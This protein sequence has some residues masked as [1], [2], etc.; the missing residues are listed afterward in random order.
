MGTPGAS[1]GSLFVPSASAPPRKRAAG[2]TGVARSKQRVLDEEE[3]IEGRTETFDI[4]SDSKDVTFTLISQCH[5][6]KLLENGSLQWTP[7]AS[8]EACTLEILARD[9][10]TH[11]SS[12]LQPQTTICFC[13]M[14]SQCLYNET[15]REGNSSLEVASCKC[16]GDTFGRFC[17][18][19]KDLCEEPCFPDVSCTPGKGCEACPPNMT[20]DGRHCAAL[21]DPLVCQNHSCP[22]NHCY[23]HG[24]CYIS[25]APD[26]Q[27]ACT[28][29]PAFTDA[30]CFLAGNNFTPTIFKELPL[31]TIVLS[32]REDENASLGDVNASVSVACWTPSGNQI[33]KGSH[34]GNA[35]TCTSFNYL[36]FPKEGSL[37]P[38]GGSR[39]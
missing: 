3:Y 1:A 33:L 14:E 4:T 39:V 19:S 8:P 24:H 30:R 9:A 15:S 18:R 29:P 27:P 23:N 28:C 5:G 26:C 13:N 12:V 37:L 7:P 17:D 11:L 32:L 34:R 2:E 35:I 6:F 22:A 36:N 21:V 10:R 25:G 20:G 38:R 31:R 16:D